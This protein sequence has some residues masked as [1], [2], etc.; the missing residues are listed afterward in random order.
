MIVGDLPFKEVWLVDFEFGVT[1]GNT[2]EP[3][4]LVAA[5]TQGRTESA[6]VARRVRRH[7]SLLDGACLAIHR[8]LRKRRNGHRT[9]L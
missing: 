8:L 5:E 6:V 7:A 3:V 9:S 2:Q 1:P 4:C